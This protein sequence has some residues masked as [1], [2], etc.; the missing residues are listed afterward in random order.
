MA[1]IM[2]SGSIVVVIGVIFVILVG[3]FVSGCSK[4]REPGARY[5]DSP[6][7][8][9][10][11]ITLIELGALS[12][13]PCQMMIPIMEELAK[14]YAGRVNIEFI[15][16]HKDNTAVRKFAIMVIPTQVIYDREKKEVFRHVGF[17]EKGPLVVELDK[18]LQEKKDD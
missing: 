13:K 4:G 17:I 9:E 18:L 3:F 1:Q 11:A 5:V 10:G 15:N 14:E 2:R 7:V 16:V 12:C 8:K 6:L